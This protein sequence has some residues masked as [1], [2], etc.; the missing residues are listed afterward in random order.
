MDGDENK[1][2]SGQKSQYSKRVSNSPSRS[3]RQQ[4]QPHNKN[5][6]EPESQQSLVEPRNQQARHPLKHRPKDQHAQHPQQGPKSPHA[7]QQ[8]QQQGPKGPNSRQQKQEQGPKRSNVYQQKQQQQ[9]LTSP[10]A[11]QK[12]S[13]QQL[14]AKN[15]SQQQKHRPDQ[16]PQITKQEGKQTSSSNQV[17]ERT[18]SNIPDSSNEVVSRHSLPRQQGHKNDCS[19]NR[20]SI[21]KENKLHFQNNTPDEYFR[22]PIQPGLAIREAIRAEIRSQN[23]RSESASSEIQQPSKGQTSDS[24]RQR[25]IND[26]QQPTDI[27]FSDSIQINEAPQYEHNTCRVSQSNPENECPNNDS[28]RR[29][30]EV[31]IREAIIFASQN[32]PENKCSTNESNRP[33]T[34]VGIREAIRLAIKSQPENECP[35]NESIRPRT[36][37]GIRE[38]IRLASQNQPEN[39]CPNNESIRPRTE[40]G[41]REAIRLASQ[42][43]PENECSTNESIRPRTE[44]GIREAI[45]LAIQSQ[46]ENECPTNE[47]I[48][49][50]FEVGI[51]EAIRLAIQ[52]Q[53][54]NECPTNEPPTRRTQ[55]SAQKPTNTHRSG[56]VERKE[57]PENNHDVSTL[58]D[59]L[60]S[61]AASFDEKTVGE[62]ENA[63]Q[64]TNRNLKCTAVLAKT[65]QPK[66]EDMRCKRKRTRARSSSSEREPQE[67]FERKN[68]PHEKEKE[69]HQLPDNCSSCH[70]QYTKKQSKRQLKKE[71]KKQQQ[72]KKQLE[73]REK[74]L[75]KKQEGGLQLRKSQVYK[76]AR[77]PGGQRQP[78]ILSPRLPNKEDSD[79]PAAGEERLSRVPT[80]GEGQREETTSEDSVKSISTYANHDTGEV[81][82]CERTEQEKSDEHRNNTQREVDQNRRFFWQNALDP[83]RQMDIQEFYM[84]KNRMLAAVN[85]KLRS[86]LEGENKNLDR[87]VI[88]KNRNTEETVP[89]EE[90]QQTHIEELSWREEVE[91]SIQLNGRFQTLGSLHDAYQRYMG[92]I[93]AL[94]KTR[95]C[96]LILCELVDLH[97]HHGRKTNYVFEELISL[98]ALNMKVHNLESFLSEYHSF[99]FFSKN[100][101]TQDMSFAPRELE[102]TFL[103]C[104][105]MVTQFLR[106][107]KVAGDIQGSR[108]LEELEATA[109]ANSPQRCLGINRVRELG[110]CIREAVEHMGPEERWQL[111]QIMWQD[112]ETETMNSQRTLTRIMDGIDLIQSVT[113]SDV[114]TARD[115]PSTVGSMSDGAAQQNQTVGSMSDGTAQQNH[116]VGSMSGGAAQQNHTVGSMS[117]GAAQ[118]NHTSEEDKQSTSEESSGHLKQTEAYSKTDDV[119]T[120]ECDFEK[121]EAGQEDAYWEKELKNADNKKKRRAI[122]KK[123]KRLRKKEMKCKIEEQQPPE[124]EADVAETLKEAD[125]CKEHQTGH[126]E[127]E[128]TEE[129]ERR[130]RYFQEED[131]ARN[132]RQDRHNQQALSRLEE[133]RSALREFISRSALTPDDTS[134]I[135]QTFLEFVLHLK[136]CQ[137]LDI[138]TKQINVM[139][140]FALNL[141]LHNC[142]V[143]QHKVM[144]LLQCF[145]Q[146]DALHLQQSS[147][148]RE[149]ERFCAEEENITGSGTNA[150]HVEPQ[151]VEAYSN[152]VSEPEVNQL[153]GAGATASKQRHEVGGGTIA[154]AVKVSKMKLDQEVTCHKVLELINYLDCQLD[155]KKAKQGHKEPS[156]ES[157]KENVATGT[158]KSA[159]AV[160]SDRE[161]VVAQSH[162]KQREHGSPRKESEK[163]LSDHKA[164]EKESCQHDETIK[165]GNDVFQFDKEL[166]G[167]NQRRR[168]ST[169]AGVNHAQNTEKPNTSYEKRALYNYCK[170]WIKEE[171][172]LPGNAREGGSSERDTWESTPARRQ[173]RGSIAE[174]LRA[175][176]AKRN[177]LEEQ[178]RKKDKQSKDKGC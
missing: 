21:H 114:D 123:M 98:A 162:I 40:V 63:I 102:N 16:E 170:K 64:N 27:H 101:E 73:K 154:L 166:N 3:E 59:L 67:Q 86:H 33:R 29:R 84:L 165:S 115:A 164:L 48:R 41:I 116:T 66:V 23:A 168:S 173:G 56:N 97:I 138:Q 107:E 39:E 121:Q 161:R 118:Q 153:S 37:V 65:D 69:E 151:C 169:T 75:K 32:Q 45:R 31:C 155:Q 78:N 128:L 157:N 20:E 150:V 160:T 30:I 36:E 140:Q 95:A 136:R 87:N 119:A 146:D 109:Y 14:R 24:D 103:T 68:K 91:E 43:Q 130:R 4:E 71:R 178:A 12:Q 112:V 72:Q 167:K 129:H 2:R 38:A 47:S 35:T 99:K 147:P 171:Q 50:R 28:L 58:R 158:G 17:S 46:P 163:E 9:G 149:S 131:R 22:V 10:Y 176:L 42:N 49:P 70:P 11:N 89:T 105:E 143:G 6:Q 93:Y 172:A 15:Q 25:E 82:N 111:Y 34:E 18:I 77:R 5:P 13:Q 83:P 19:D 57:S 80:A 177:Q 122:K 90:Q 79:C 74:R 113:S 135:S 44:V 126:E 61:P 120:K 100:E 108:I 127:I 76:P 148:S 85:G 7:H 81:N 133:L 141:A 174:R 159:C 60:V 104:L 52:S 175:Q 110:D 152:W 124:R 156:K 54:E 106:L 132:E 55:L 92:H 139:L 62:K 53:P 137:V 94:F 88:Q 96:R 1:E 117:D 51:R 144:L 142:D 145:D 125:N 134:E 26:V 8:T